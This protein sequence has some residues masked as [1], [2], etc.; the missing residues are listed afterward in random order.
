MARSKRVRTYE[1][2]MVWLGYMR[3]FASGPFARQAGDIG[4]V[5]MDAVKERDEAKERAALLAA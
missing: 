2:A 1:D 4:V 5:L 3:R